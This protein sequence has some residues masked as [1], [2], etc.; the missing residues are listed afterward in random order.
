MNEIA[1]I[2]HDYQFARR[3]FAKLRRSGRLKNA[4]RCPDELTIFTAHNYRNSSLLEANLQYLGIDDYVVLNRRVEVWSNSLRIKWFLEFLESNQC[5]NPLVL[6]CDADDVILR[7]SPQRIVDVF[8]T[9][10]CDALYCSTRWP[11]GYKCAPKIRR[12]ADTVH[13]DRYLNGG[14]FIGRR[15]FLI[16]VYRSVLDYVTDQDHVGNHDSHAFYRREEQFAKDFPRGVGC[17]QAILRYLEPQFYPRLKVD[18]ENNF[19]WRN[20]AR[21]RWEFVLRSMK[22][23]IPTGLKQPIKKLVPRRYDATS[24]FAGEPL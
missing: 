5:K 1:P 15:D 13:P 19:A 9:Q 10:D 21:T 18:A 17:D 12:W 24:E 16:E 11:H 22:R 2:V 7:D 8:H 20:E 23:R 6:H 4:F 14:V 3:I